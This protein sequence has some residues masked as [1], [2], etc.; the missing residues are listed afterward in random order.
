MALGANKKCG[1]VVESPAGT[2]MTSQSSQDVTRLLARI[3]TGDEAATAELLDVAYAELRAI[4]GHLFREQ[5]RDHTL[6]PTALVNEVCARLL[7]ANE[8]S[9]NDRKHFF[10][11]AAKAM[12]NLLTDHARAKN[13]LRRGGG[14]VRISLDSG[15]IPAAPTEV[16]LVALDE[17]LTKLSRLDERLG[18]IFE[19]R[20]LVGLSVEKTAEIAEVSPRTVELDTQ[21]IRAWLQKELAG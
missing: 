15:Q 6:Q 5:P 1:K 7:N 19:L 11:A 4:A 17:T 9:W 21:F 16:D 13:S 20:F 3:H 10:R 12:R 8:G 14:G 2:L 18:Q